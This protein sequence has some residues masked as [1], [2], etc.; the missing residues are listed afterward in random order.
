MTKRGIVLLLLFAFVNVSLFAQQ[1]GLLIY[2]NIQTDKNGDIVPWYNADPAIAYDH[3]L[4]TIWSFWFNMLRDMNGLPYYMNHQVWNPNFDDP[5]GIGG[6]QFMMAISSWRLL[7]AYTGDE[8]IKENACFLAGYYLTHGLSPANCKYPDIPFPYNT[9]IYS[10]VYDGDMRNG[11]DVAQLDKAGSLGL[12]L[13]HLYKIKNDPI[14]LDAAVKIANTLAA[15]VKTGDADHSPL[16]F[17]VNVY[18]GKTVLLNTTDKP[19]NNVKD[20]AC[21]TSNLTPTLQMFDDLIELK[22]G[23]IAAYKISFDKILA[24]AK[25]YPVQNNKWGPFF[26][27]V[28]EWSETQINAMT[29]ARYMMEHPQYFPEWKTQVKNIINWVHT[30]FANDK[31]KK[32]GVIVTNEQT[33]YP[34]PGNSH[35]ARQAADELLY[36]YLSGDTSLYT[37]AIHELNWATY[38]VDVDGKNCFPTDEPWLTDGY[39]DYIRHYL[40]AMATYPALAPAEDHILSTTSVIQQADYKGYLKKF[41]YLNFDKVDT[42]KV[43]LFYRTFDKQGT[44]T[45]RMK[46]KPSAVLLNDQPMKEVNADE[47][48]TWNALEKGGVLT[49]R[50]KNGD[51]V[52]V[53]N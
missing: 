50:R 25:K 12:E 15:N 38:A 36:S 29:C 53:L 23:N 32:Y 49:V 4:H 44:E 31:W 45:I 47:G 33:V 43:R 13:I 48:Y 46:A 51:K 17:K 5:R 37:N 19:Y 1:G 7:Y 2:H 52:I 16:P 24:W 27:D 42:N 6:D 41:I 18:T 26:E 10:G 8:N 20:T 11:K 30:N 9:L 35:S 40:R 39:G 22:K 21:Y 34:V 3:N 28:G 14:F